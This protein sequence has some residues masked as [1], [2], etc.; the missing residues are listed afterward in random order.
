MDLVREWGV[1]LCL[2]AAGCALLRFLAP[3]TALGRVLER[4]SAVALLCCALAPLGSSWLFSLPQTDTAVS[5]QSALQQQVIAQLREPLA[6]A[7]QQAGEQALA[8][9]GLKAEKITAQMDI[10]E[11]G[12]IYI[13]EICVTV[14]S[15]QAVKSGWI[16]EILSERFSCDAVRVE[17]QKAGGGE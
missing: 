10:D 6:A 1:A 15:R 9:Y 14:D 7:V 4:V 16:R 11:D 2:T 3:D 12:G 5:G 13:S 17:S 8:S